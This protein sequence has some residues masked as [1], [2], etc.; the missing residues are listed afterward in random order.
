MA[1]RLPPLLLSASLLCAAC[2]AAGGAAATADAEPPDDL[3]ESARALLSTNCGECHTRGSP[4]ALPRA[5]A[6]YDLDQTEWSQRM[7]ADQLREAERRLREPT[8]PTRGEDEIRTIRATPEELDRFRQY[9]E[10]EI[11]RRP[12]RDP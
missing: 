8:A 3:R 7:T 9:V 1:A 11:A 5:L 12:S 6:V 10:R 2:R 4:N